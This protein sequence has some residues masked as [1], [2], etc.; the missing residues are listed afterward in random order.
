MKVIYDHQI[1]SQE[2]G[3]IS[4][5]F[6]NLITEITNLKLSDSKKC[7]LINKNEYFKGVG[8]I[9]IRIYKN[10]I[11][12][13]IINKRPFRIFIQIANE[14][15][16]LWHLKY[17]KYDVIH[18][19]GD[20]ISYIINNRINKPIV[21]TIHDLIPEIYPDFFP[22]IDDRLEKR[23]EAI[24]A[25]NHFIAISESTKNDLIKFYN[26]KNENITVIHHGCPTL[27]QTNNKKT[28]IIPKDKKYL[29]F[30][31]D[32]NAEYKNFK[33]LILALS[34]FL[35]AENDLILVCVGSEL[36]RFES[37]FIKDLGIG[38]K[39]LAFRATDEEL[40]SIYKN[41]SCFIYPS[42]YEGFGLP[43]LE[44]MS[45]ECPIICSNTSCFPEI[46][47]DAVIYFNP[48]TFNGLI[49]GLKMILENRIVRENLK[50][51][52][53][54]R[55]KDFSWKKSAELTIGAYLKAITA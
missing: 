49:E 35:K 44:A 5:Y 2:I 40:F 9:N 31:G 27:T 18:A 39:V 38:D 37:L 36:S 33:K 12:S 34:E 51:K 6:Y 48:L 42:L 52:Q 28:N 55:V 26:I 53:A 8:F 13:K 41:S 16:S 11:F 23:K 17:S 45:A 15:F 1:F 30:V 20:N 24:L 29:L 21:L 4:R 22:D 32:R 7:V 14:L 43:L 46:G 47:Q 10:N 50:L 19:T 54:K 3:G 25:A